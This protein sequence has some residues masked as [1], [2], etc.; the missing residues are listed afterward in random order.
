MV[1][2]RSRW[3]EDLSCIYRA[4]REY[5]NFARWIEDAV[6]ILSRMNPKISMDRKAVEILSRRKPE[7]L[8]DRESVKMLSSRQ[9]A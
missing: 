1:K 5:K 9:R 3:I 4:N 2:G 7:I 6:E 8:M